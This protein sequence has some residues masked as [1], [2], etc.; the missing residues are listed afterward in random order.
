[1]T[2][3]M[4]YF[5]KFNK[6]LI[7]TEYGADA[8]SGI[9]ESVP[10]MFSEEYQEEF[11]KRINAVLDRYN[12]VIGEHAWNFADFQT[13]QGTMRV[14]GNKKGIFT[15]DRKPKLAAHYFKR[16]WKSIPDFEYKK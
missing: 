5:K 9:H 6:P 7:I 16:R 10:S 15:R 4:E 11:Y 8:V 3:E 14:D 2:A 1:M 12:F 13:V